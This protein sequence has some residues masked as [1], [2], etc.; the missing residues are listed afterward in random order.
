MPEYK[1]TF[2]RLARKELQALPVEFAERL[3]E[4]IE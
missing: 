1:I 4:K 3:L 2:A